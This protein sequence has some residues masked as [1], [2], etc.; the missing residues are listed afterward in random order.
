MAKANTNT[1]TT[2]SAVASLDD[3][4]LLALATEVLPAAHKISGL[5]AQEVVTEEGV[6]SVVIFSSYSWLTYRVAA[7]DEIEGDPAAYRA[8]LA[9]RILG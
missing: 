7:P 2:A 9:A 3:T 1:N 4:A 8:A 5:S 6:R